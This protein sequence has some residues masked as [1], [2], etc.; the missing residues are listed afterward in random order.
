MVLRA[1]EVSVAVNDQMRTSLEITTPVTYLGPG[2]RWVLEPL[3]LRVV[4][5]IAPVDS[6]C[7]FSV[8]RN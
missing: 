5:L 3:I 2:R 7:R 4:N 8:G 6:I 1:A